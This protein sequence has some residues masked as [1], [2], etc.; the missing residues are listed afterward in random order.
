MTDF[1][2]IRETLKKIG[3]G[4]NESKIYLTLIKLGPSMAGKIAKESNIDRSAS[5]DS[6]KSLMKKGLVSYAIE[7]NRKKFSASSPE[8]LKSYLDEKQELVSGILGDLKNMYKNTEEKSQVNMFK[9]FKGMKTV[10]DD[11]LNS[12]KGGENLVIDSSGVF[13]EKMPYYMPHF[14]KGLE[15]N[16][17]KVRHIVRKD[18]EKT[19][20]SSKTTQIRFFPKIVGEQTITTNIYADKVALILWTD[21]PEAVIIKNKAAAEAYRSYF[22]ILWKTA[23]E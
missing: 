10:F 22:E 9:G 17:I 12:A 7:A 14:V 18:K 13:G 2:S 20:N 23:K 8:K 11:I 19:L 16:K 4:H 21:V 3:L 15:Q 5:Y 1:D 6:L